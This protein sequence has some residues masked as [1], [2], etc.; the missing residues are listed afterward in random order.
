MKWQTS[1][2]PLRISLLKGWADDMNRLIKL[3]FR[4]LRKQKSFYI[5]TVIMIGLLFLGTLTSNALANAAPELLEQLDASG[6]GN[7][8]AAVSNSSFVLI[9][10]IFTAL[11]VCEDHEQNT[12][13][14]IYARGFSRLQ[15]YFSK[16]ISI[17]LATSVMFLLVLAFSF[18]F[19]ALFFGVGSIDSLKLLALLGVQY[20]ASMAN[21]ALCFAISSVLRRNGSSIAATIL[22]PMLVNVVLS[23]VDSFL[24][25]EDFSTT[26]IWLS[27]FLGDLG[28]LAVSTERMLVC[29]VASLIYI[30]V[31]IVAGAYFNKKIE[32]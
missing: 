9:A 30:P 19:G 15:V 32:L 23:L 18:L 16:M 26:T 8:I 31:F 5:C 20:I 25:F 13:K 6:I 21:I 28:T 12:V 4:K 2:A 22:A 29:L 3:E 7:L 1:K 17:F 27:S 24:K 14:T 11:C 10:G